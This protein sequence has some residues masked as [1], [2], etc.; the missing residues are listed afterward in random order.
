MSA[1]GKDLRL[2]NSFPSRRVGLMVAGTVTPSG[3][4]NSGPGIPCG[5]SGAGF[6]FR[7]MTAPGSGTSPSSCSCSCS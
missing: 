3:N 5:I 6:C 1:R 4:P 2:C 7:G